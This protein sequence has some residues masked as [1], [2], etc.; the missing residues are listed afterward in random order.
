MKLPSDFWHFNV[1]HAASLAALAGAVYGNWITLGE[2]QARMADLLGD[3]RL[4]VRRIDHEGTAASQ[5][6]IYHESEFSKSTE[7]RVSAVESLVPSINEMRADIGWIKHTL[8]D[9]QTK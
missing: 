4:E 8:Q 3:L 9:R 6:G 2:R 5:R 7:R 1:G